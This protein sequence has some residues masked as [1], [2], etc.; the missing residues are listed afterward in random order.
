MPCTTWMTARGGPSG[1]QRRSARALP[2]TAVSVASS[3]LTAFLVPHRA[4][5]SRPDVVINVIDSSNLERN[6]YLT[7]QL[8]DMHVRMV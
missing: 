2:S 3:D 6:L 1:S 4:G 8:I 5:P 7:T